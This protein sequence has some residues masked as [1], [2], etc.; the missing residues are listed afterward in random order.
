MQRRLL[1]LP[2]QVLGETFHVVIRKGRIEPAAANAILTSYRSF[3]IV[4][5][6]HEVDILAAIDAFARHRLSFWDAVIWAVCQRC[7]VTTL[8]TE[9][10]QD[11]R[12]LGHV[13][14]MNPFGGRA[15]RCSMAEPPARPLRRT[16]AA[17]AEWSGSPGGPAPASSGWR[18]P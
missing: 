11:G 12:T 6:Y 17:M 13:T 8:F 2:L 9:D 7:G 14:F 16:R 5:P 18:S 3:A 4:E 10:L 1:F 15:A